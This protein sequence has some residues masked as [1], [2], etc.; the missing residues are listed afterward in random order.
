MGLGGVGAF[1]VR[2]SELG[3]DGEQVGLA[4][5]ARWDLLTEQF[6]FS[7]CCVGSTKY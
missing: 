1:S 2:G 6:G 5:A 4:F 7:A 3:E